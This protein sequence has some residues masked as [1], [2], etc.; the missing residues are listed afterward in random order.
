MKTHGHALCILVLLSRPCKSEYFTSVLLQSYQ[1]S[2]ITSAIKPIYEVLGSVTSFLAR[3]FLFVLFF[4]LSC[5][6]SVKFFPGPSLS[7]GLTQLFRRLCLLTSESRSL[8]A[9]FLESDSFDLCF[10]SFG[11]SAN[12]SSLKSAVSFKSCG[13]SLCYN[14]SGRISFSPLVS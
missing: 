12:V 11:T 7:C 1:W 8:V 2:E 6:L 3:D 10:S 13:E 5:Q 14:V 4:S 9:L